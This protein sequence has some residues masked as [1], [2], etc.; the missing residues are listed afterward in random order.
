M[1]KYKSPYSFVYCKAKYNNDHAQTQLSILLHFK[2]E[3]TNA[4]Y[5][6]VCCLDLYSL[7]VITNEKMVINDAYFLETKD[8]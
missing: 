4:L 6:S 5:L 2:R 3:N 1:E 7:T 8:H